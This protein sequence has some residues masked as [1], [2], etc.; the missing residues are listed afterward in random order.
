ML[1]PLWHVDATVVVPFLLDTVA[2]LD[3]E[4]ARTIAMKVGSEGN[5][6]QSTRH[7]A[8]CAQGAYFLEC[9][10]LQVEADSPLR[11]AGRL[12]YHAGLNPGSRLGFARRGA[13]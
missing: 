2:A 7:D 5:T 12:V 8:Q 13:R 11:C 9:T 6:V 1:E 4:L 10:R 3:K